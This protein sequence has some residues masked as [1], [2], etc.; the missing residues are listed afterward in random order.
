MGPQAVGKNVEVGDGR[1]QLVPNEG[2]QL[3]CV[4]VGLVAKGEKSPD[5]A[6][7]FAPITSRL[8]SPGVPV[9]MFAAFAAPQELGQEIKRVGAQAAALPPLSG[10]AV[11]LRIT[12]RKLSEG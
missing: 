2:L 7:P 10:L 3:V 12:G 5:A 9:Q 4:Y 1:D 6:S 8:T 11:P